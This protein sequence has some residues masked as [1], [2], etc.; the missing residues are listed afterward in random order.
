MLVWDLVE[1][2]VKAWLQRDEARQGWEVVFWGRQTHGNVE[3]VWNKRA[4]LTPHECNTYTHDLLLVI[5]LNMESQ[6]CG[7]SKPYYTTATHLV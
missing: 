4:S 3:Q 1:V 7:Y 5:I 2:L 6:V